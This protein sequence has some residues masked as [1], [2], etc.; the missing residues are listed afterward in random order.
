[1]GNTDSSSSSINSRCSSSTTISGV[2]A[3]FLP[4]TGDLRPAALVAG[5]AGLGVVVV[6]MG[7]E[8]AEFSWAL[9]V[10]T[11]CSE[12]R[13]NSLVLCCSVF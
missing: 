6:V 1:M 5:G 3:V 10:A 13:N 11:C 2:V 8:E 7:S 9:S 4:L 12:E